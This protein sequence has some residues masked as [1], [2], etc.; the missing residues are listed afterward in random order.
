MS[1]SSEVVAAARAVEAQSGVDAAALVA[2]SIVETNARAFAPV[3]DRREPLIRFE[4]HCFDR[5][6]DGDK[7][8]IARLAGLSAPRAGQ[9]RNPAG[10]DARWRLL[11]QASAIDAEAAFEATS[12]GLGQVMGSHWRQLG[13]ASAGEMAALARRSAEGQLE[14]V[15]RFLRTGPFVERLE[16][17]DWAGFARLYNGPGFAANGYDAKIAGAW[18]QATRALAAPAA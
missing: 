8:R 12:W 9:I 6:L 14:I 13:F 17:G 10:Q 18:R 16:R 2:V 3:G 7:R 15:A 11:A 5:L 1:I 4:G